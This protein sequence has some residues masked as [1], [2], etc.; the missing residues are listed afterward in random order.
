M[1][2][3]HGLSD[4][5][6]ALQF[7]WAWQHANQSV[8]FKY[9]LGGQTAASSLLIQSK[10]VERSSEI[11]LIL[12]RLFGFR[13]IDFAFREIEYVFEKYSTTNMLF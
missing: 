10:S 4:Y 8:C 2:I 9:A 6:T 3:V 1:V 12:E 5:Q 11:V 7:E 13:E